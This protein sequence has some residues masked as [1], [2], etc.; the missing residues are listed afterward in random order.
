M[1]ILTENLAVLTEQLTLTKR[2]FKT[3]VA[4]QGDEDIIPWYSPFPR[5]PTA[6]FGQVLK[7]ETDLRRG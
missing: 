4:V 1:I 3:E 6:I 5:K 2:K 7:L